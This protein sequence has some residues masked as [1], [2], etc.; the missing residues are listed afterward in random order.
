MTPG[1]VSI[2]T[3]AALFPLHTEGEGEFVSIWP[4]QDSRNQRQA[5]TGRK[6]SLGKGLHRKQRTAA[7]SGRAQ[8]QESS[9]A[10]D[11]KKPQQRGCSGD[12]PARGLR[13]PAAPSPAPTAC[14]PRA[15]PAQ[16]HCKA[17]A[18]CVS[19]PVSIPAAQPPH[20]SSGTGIR[21]ATT[22]SPAG[23]QRARRL[24]GVQG[25]HAA[26][27]SPRASPRPQPV[28]RSSCMNKQICLQRGTASVCLSV[29]QHPPVKE[30]AA[31]E[32]GTQRA[33]SPCGHPS[34]RNKDTARIR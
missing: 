16:H 22:P 9:P 23:R 3:R 29:R 7:R 6:P 11:L 25:C 1:A 27:T 12:S 30:R 4:R 26:L 28:S 10:G 5:R 34:P 17:A 32:G 24:L 8:Q 20:D 21:R 13:A 14:H 15:A 31:Q 19:I 2:H 18:L 33:R